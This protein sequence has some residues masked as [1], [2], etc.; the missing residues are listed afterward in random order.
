[1][2]RQRFHR[3]DVWTV[4]FEPVVGSEQGRARPAV[5][6]QNDIGNRYSPLLIVAAIT[7]GE[8]ASY[9]V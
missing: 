2:S 4:N 6:I 9:D 7:P 1:M 3:G 5:L 8:M